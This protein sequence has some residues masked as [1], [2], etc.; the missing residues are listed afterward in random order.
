MTAGISLM[1]QTARKWGLDDYRL[2]LYHYHSSQHEVSLLVIWV[3]F[4][5]L[6]HPTKEGHIS[7]SEKYI[8]ALLYIITLCLPLEHTHLLGEDDSNLSKVYRAPSLGRRNSHAGSAFLVSNHF[9][10]PSFWCSLKIW[11]FPA[12]PSLE[13]TFLHLS[14]DNHCHTVLA[15]SFTNFAQTLR[16]QNIN[17]LIGQQRRIIIEMKNR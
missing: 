7:E 13:Q 4:H 9:L 16:I 14:F 1:R 3:F 11:T 12:V 15:Q 17:S 6:A 2:S 10:L 8:L 5:C